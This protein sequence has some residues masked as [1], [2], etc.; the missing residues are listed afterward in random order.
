MIVFQLK[1]Y[2]H[3]QFSSPILH[4]VLSQFSFIKRTSLPIQS[5]THFKGPS[6]NKMLQKRI[7]K[8][9]CQIGR[10]NAASKAQEIVFG[11]SGMMTVEKILKVQKKIGA[12]IFGQTSNLQVG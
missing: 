4:C 11:G 10:V 9:D 6:Q 12:V 2:L 8:S 7:E 5:V 1:V 3:V